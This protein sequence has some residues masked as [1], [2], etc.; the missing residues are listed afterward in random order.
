MTKRRAN[1]GGKNGAGRNGNGNGNGNGKKS[2]VALEMAELDVILKA[3]QKYRST[4]PH[5]LQSAQPELRAVED[6][7]RKLSQE[8]G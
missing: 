8:R 3:C 6:V 2:R 7:I 4:M 5:Y 1:S